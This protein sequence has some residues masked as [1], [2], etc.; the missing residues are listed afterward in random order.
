M[1]RSGAIGR[2]HIWDIDGMYMQGRHHAQE[3]EQYV[4]LHDTIECSRLLVGQNIA[5]KSQVTNVHP[6][7]DLRVF[8]F[9]RMQYECRSVQD[10]T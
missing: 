10:A 3:P 1:A 9:H 7:F 5:P 8:K 2:P 6:D 4:F